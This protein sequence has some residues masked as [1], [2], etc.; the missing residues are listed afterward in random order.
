MLGNVWPGLSKDTSLTIS[1]GE[2]V[3]LNLWRFY[4]VLLEL[5]LGTVSCILDKV[6][7]QKHVA[8]GKRRRQKIKA[9]EQSRS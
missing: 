1:L 5:Y 8:E 7:S 3:G 9:H 6:C 2:K 4:I